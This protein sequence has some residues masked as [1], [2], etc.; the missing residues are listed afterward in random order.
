MEGDFGK[1][2]FIREIPSQFLGT[3]LQAVQPLFIKIDNSE[4]IG[5]RNKLMAKS[6]C[7]TKESK[8]RDFLQQVLALLNADN[9][10]IANCDSLYL[11]SIIEEASNIYFPFCVKDSNEN[12]INAVI[13]VPKDS[14]KKIEICFGFTME[15]KRK[16]SGIV[17]LLGKK[18]QNNF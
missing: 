18:R 7:Q 4:N 8:W 1:L 13:Q 12:W 9:F 16:V 2:S 14:S 11:K 3:G 6:H 5:E 15:V 10:P 17:G